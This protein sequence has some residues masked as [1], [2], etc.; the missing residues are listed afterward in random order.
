MPLSRRAIHSFSCRS[1][2]GLRPF[3]TAVVRPG[4][5]VTNKICGRRHSQGVHLRSSAVQD[6]SLPAV[7]TSSS[8][9]AS[10]AQ[11]LRRSE[12][13]QR[14]TEKTMEND[15]QAQLPK[16]KGTATSILEPELVNCITWQVSERSYRGCRLSACT[17]RAWRCG[18]RGLA[19]RPCSLSGH[20]RRPLGGR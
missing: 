14:V 17:R 12:I 8:P 15:G 6:L 20:R 19:L 4:T 11:V 18:R 1:L 10:S 13:L 7:V 16:A 3:W 9:R 2:P 5:W